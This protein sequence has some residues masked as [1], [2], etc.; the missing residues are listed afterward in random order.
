[1]LGEKRAIRTKNYLASLGVPVEQLHIMSFGKDNPACWDSTEPCYQ[2]NRRA[3]LVLDVSV[4][5]TVLQY[6]A[7][8]TE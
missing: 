6:S 1:V 8:R 5:S 2:K 3:H 7:D 4:A